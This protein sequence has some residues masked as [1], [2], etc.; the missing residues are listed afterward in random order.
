[1]ELIYEGNATKIL[2]DNGNETKISYM[3]GT[4]KYLL[5]LEDEGYIEVWYNKFIRTQSAETYVLL[6]HENFLKANMST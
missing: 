6:N 3:I 4:N 2:D 1:M 5:I